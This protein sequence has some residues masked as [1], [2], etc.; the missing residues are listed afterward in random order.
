MD[1]IIQYVISINEEFHSNH[2]NLADARKIYRSII[3]LAEV[4]GRSGKVSLVKKQISFKILSE[5]NFSEESVFNSDGFADS[6][7]L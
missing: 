4:E 7:S 3:N 5:Q 2:D 6:I 1:N